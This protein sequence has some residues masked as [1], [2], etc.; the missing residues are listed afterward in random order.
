MLA[1][2]VARTLGMGS[3]KFERLSLSAEIRIAYPG[4]ERTPSSVA[5]QVYAGHS[6]S[7]FLL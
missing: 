3:R 6:K 2:F 5:G 7:T 1:E 4:S